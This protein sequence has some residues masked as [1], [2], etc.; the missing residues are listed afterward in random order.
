MRTVLFSSVHDW[1]W[2]RQISALYPL[3]SIF[4]FNDEVSNF[5]NNDKN[6]WVVVWDEPRKGRIPQF[7]PFERRILWITEPSCYKKYPIWF[8]NQYKYIVTPNQIQV[9]HQCIQ[10]ISPPLINWFYGINIDNLNYD[11]CYHIDRMLNA[12]PPAKSMKI[13]IVCSNIQTIKNHQQRLYFV[14]ILQKIFKDRIDF[15]GRGFNKIQNK[16]N[17]IN[18]YFY[19]ICLENNFEENFWTEKVTDAYLGW[20][21]PVYSGCPNLEA[22][23]PEQ[24]FIRIDYRNIESSVKVIYK[25]L[26][27][28]DYASR[29]ESISEARWRVLFKY[30]I[31]RCIDGIL[32]QIENI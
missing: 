19:T 18:D 1:P 31:F 11:E 20:S 28:D 15:Y 30:N 12:K 2:S 24:S 13:S 10:L 4:A 23:F 17:A 32:D 21:V 25:L 22:Y 7:I 5:E 6:L 9:D 3:K 27:E 29:L 26:E 16:A 14:Q 8:T